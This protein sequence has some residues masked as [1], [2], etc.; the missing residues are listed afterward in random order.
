MGLLSHPGGQE[1]P[2]GGADLEAAKGEPCG[3]L[4]E[5]APAKDVEQGLG[6]GGGDWCAGKGAEGWCGAVGR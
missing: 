3:Y 2:L 5:R 4:G 1:K 6:G